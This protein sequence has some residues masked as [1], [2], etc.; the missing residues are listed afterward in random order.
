MAPGVGGFSHPWDTCTKTPSGK[1]STRRAAASLARGLGGSAEPQHHLLPRPGKKSK[2]LG[3]VSANAPMQ[4]AKLYSLLFIYLTILKYLLLALTK[5]KNRGALSSHEERGYVQLWRD[6]GSPLH[7]KKNNINKKSASSIKK[8]TKS[9][10]HLFTLYITDHT[11]I[12]T[13]WHLALGLQN[14]VS[15]WFHPKATPRPP[16]A[17]PQSIPLGKEPASRSPCSGCSRSAGSKHLQVHT[18]GEPVFICALP[19]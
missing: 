10:K 6:L 1:G 7:T 19:S 16:R 11:R 13:S 5:M 8:R 18:P 17:R 15:G 12:G 3:R 2:K 4:K 14:L 9:C